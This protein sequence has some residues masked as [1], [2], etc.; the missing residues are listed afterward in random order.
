MT[1][2][3]HVFLSS[4]YSK[5]SSYL[6]VPAQSQSFR[7]IKFKNRIWKAFNEIQM[8]IFKILMIFHKHACE[9]CSKSFL[10]KLNLPSSKYRSL[11][12]LQIE[13]FRK[14]IYNGF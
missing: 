10:R 9:S 14:Q 8:Q 4:T 3:Q 6:D 11:L 5:N 12:M 13:T 7:E 2:V 1:V